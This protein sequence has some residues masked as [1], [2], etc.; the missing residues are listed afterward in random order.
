M[1]MGFPFVSSVSHIL[2]YAATFFAGIISGGMEEIKESMGIL[3]PP[4]L[5]E[6]CHC[7][8]Q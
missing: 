6:T 3:G 2:F 8:T 1:V 7:A 5:E 4:K